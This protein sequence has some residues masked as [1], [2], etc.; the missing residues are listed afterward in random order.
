MDRCRT[1]HWG[2]PWA[3]R[4][5]CSSLFG[6]SGTPRHSDAPGSSGCSR[7]GT[8]AFTGIPRGRAGGG[9]GLPCLQPHCGWAQTMHLLASQAHRAPPSPAPARLESGALG[10]THLWA[11]LYWV[12]SN[13]KG[14]LPRC[15]GMGQK[16]GVHPLTSQHSPS[17]RSCRGMEGSPASSPLHLPLVGQVRLVAHQRD[18]DVTAPSV[19]TLIWAAPPAC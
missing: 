19:Q 2:Q 7:L 5:V 15:R 14:S 11:S 17:R 9:R 1:G 3:W 4:A 6:E 18:D 12:L 8:R 10:M 13:P 16:K